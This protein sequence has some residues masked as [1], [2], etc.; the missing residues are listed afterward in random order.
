MYP[1]KAPTEPKEVQKVQIVRDPPPAKAPPKR[2]EG[3]GPQ[4][5]ERR[6]VAA[7][8][9]RAKTCPPQPAPLEVK[10]APPKLPDSLRPLPPAMLGSRAEAIKLAKDPQEAAIYKGRKIAEWRIKANAN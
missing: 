1:T 5:T 10:K 6:R 2:G 8:L 4:A 9:D 3:V 7:E